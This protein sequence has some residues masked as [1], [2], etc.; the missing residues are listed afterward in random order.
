MH[1]VSTRGSELHFNYLSKSFMQFNVTP[2]NSPN[3]IS[4]II[5]GPSSFT[6]GLLQI[7]ATFIL[8]Q[9]TLHRIEC[10]HVE[11]Y[12]PHPEDGGSNSIEHCPF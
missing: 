5:V 3:T 11:R 4:R 1:L 6:F 10:K 7:T 9:R 8:Q 12:F 2:L